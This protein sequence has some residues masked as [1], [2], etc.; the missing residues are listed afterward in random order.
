MKFSILVVMIIALICGV[1]GEACTSPCV[2]TY[3]QCKIS[4]PCASACVGRGPP[5][6]TANPDICPPAD[7]AEANCW[8]TISQ[9]YHCACFTFFATCS[10]KTDDQL[11]VGGKCIMSGGGIAVAVVVP[12]VV[13]AVIGLIIWGCRRHHHKQKYQEIH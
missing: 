13:V 10:T 7:S 11:N 1:S 3:Q 5:C 2:T 6:L 8:S 9:S 12:I 4:A